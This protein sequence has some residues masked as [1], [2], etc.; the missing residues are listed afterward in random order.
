MNFKNYILSVLAI[1]ILVPMLSCAM[2]NQPGAEGQPQVEGRPHGAGRN[3]APQPNGRNNDRPLWKTLGA[4]IIATGVG[5]VSD[6]ALKK[7]WEDKE[8][9][10]LWTLFAG[11][12]LLFGPNYVAYEMGASQQLT[13]IAT[14]SSAVLAHAF[15]K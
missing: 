6:Y 3:R 15:N 8:A 14:V 1:A 9:G 13:A 2:D 11:T 4:N 12:N 10:I 7:F 5:V